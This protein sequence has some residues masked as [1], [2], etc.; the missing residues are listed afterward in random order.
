MNKVVSSPNMIV[1][2]YFQS[3]R[4]LCYTIEQH[5]EHNKEQIQ[6]DA[7]LGVILAVTGVEI[8][9]NVYFRVLVDEETYKHAAP[10][11]LNDLKKQ[12]PLEKKVKKWPSAVFGKKLNFGEGVGQLF[13]NLKILRNKLVHFSSSHETIDLPGHKIQ[14]MADTSIYSSLDT[15]SAINALEVAEQFIC[16]IFRLSGIGEKEFPHALHLWTGK[17]PTNKTIGNIRPH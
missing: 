6:Q 13:T 7:A 3:L 2:Q 4:R 14:G 17:V 9:V 15:H 8:F 5:D 16:E 10:Y 12:L 1:C 11:I